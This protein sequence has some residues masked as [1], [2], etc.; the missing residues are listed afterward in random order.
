MK[1]RLTSLA[2]LSLF[3]VAS[4]LASPLTTAMSLGSGAY[5]D[6]TYGT[7]VKEKEI[8]CTQFIVVVLEKYLQMSLSAEIRALVNINGISEL[9]GLTEE[10]VK[11]KLAD[12][13]LAEDERTKGV[14]HA[15]TK[16]GVGREVPFLEVREGDVVQY[17]M[18]GSG[19]WFGHAA[20]IE[21]IYED[22]SGARRMKLYGAH[23]SIDGVGSSLD[24]NDIELRHNNTDRK[25]YAARLRERP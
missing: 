13:V 4:A 12:L 1:H 3:G 18:K 10:Q 2:A 7:S 21:R 23:K 14:V 25:I 11:S 19:G 6:F 24:Q 16:L 20:V 15:V 22:P 5:R 8:D 9:Q 17:W